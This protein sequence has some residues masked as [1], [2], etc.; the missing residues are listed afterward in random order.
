MSSIVVDDPSRQDTAQALAI[1]D[2]LEDSAATLGK[3]LDAAQI[4]ELC[5]TVLHAAMMEYAGTVE[6]GLFGALAAQLSNT[7]VPA[8]EFEAWEAIVVASEATSKAIRAFEATQPEPTMLNARIY[9]GALAVLERAVN[10]A[11]I[12][13]EVGPSFTAPAYMLD[14]IVALRQFHE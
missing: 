2:G 11:H 5:N 10:C 7:F 4:T 1:L 12:L 3:L 14:A 6:G 9:G 8:P 13:R